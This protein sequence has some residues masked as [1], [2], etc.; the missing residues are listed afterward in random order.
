METSKKI[1]L[2]EPD[3]YS[4]MRASLERIMISLGKTKRE[5][6]DLEKSASIISECYH[7]EL[8]NKV[9]QPLTDAIL[10]LGEI[11]G[12]LLSDDII[13]NRLTNVSY[14]SK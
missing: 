12:F 8:E 7:S 10:F 5:L 11:N 3:N 1:I 6:K 13:E 4:E 14:E 9:L 2:E